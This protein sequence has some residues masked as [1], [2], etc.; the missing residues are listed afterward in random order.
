MAND[1]ESLEPQIPTRAA[2]AAFYF[3]ATGLRLKRG[4]ENLSAPGRLAG[5][6]T[7]PPT[8]I[9]EFHSPLWT[10]ESLVERSLQL[11]KI[12]NLRMAAR[13]LNGTV[14]QAGREFSFWRQ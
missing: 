12:Q 2:A 9:A 13:R 11:G 7:F 5:A 1:T 10:S 4:V 14:I 8:V 3:K 6:S